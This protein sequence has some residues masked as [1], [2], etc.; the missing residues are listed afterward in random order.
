MVRRVRVRGHRS[1]Y[2]SHCDDIDRSDHHGVCNTWLYKYWQEKEEEKREKKSECRYSLSVNNFPEFMRVS[3]VCMLL[4]VVN[5]LLTK[6][7][8]CRFCHTSVCCDEWKCRSR[9]RFSI[10]SF[11]SNVRVLIVSSFSSPP[12]SVFYEGRQTVLS[13][14]CFINGC[15]PQLLSSPQQSLF[16]VGAVTGRSSRSFLCTRDS[17][18]LH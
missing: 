6:W 16:S 2:G 11:A 14:S 15:F 12:T 3:E 17:E 9:D 1:E 4:I 10:N 5:T 8:E 13:R 18:V 7:L